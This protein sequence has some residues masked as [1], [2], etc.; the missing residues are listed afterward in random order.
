MSQPRMSDRRRFRPGREALEGRA[1]MSASTARDQALVLWDK[2]IDGPPQEAYI[3]SLSRQLEHG[4]SPDRLAVRLLTSEPNLR[5]TRTL[6]GFVTDLY[7]DVLG[8]APDAEGQQFWVDMLRSGRASRAQVAQT[9]VS[10]GYAA[11][12]APGYISNVTVSKAGWS[13][14]TQGSSTANAGGFYN[15]GDFSAATV[16]I[17]VTGPGT[18]T[19][20]QSGGW[21]VGNNTGSTWRRFTIGL[22]GT[23]KPAFTSSYDASGKF[24]SPSVTAT[25]V[26]YTNGSVPSGGSTYTNAFQPVT[27]ITT[28]AGGTIV[29][30]ETPG[31]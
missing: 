30:Y 17:T 24:A 4:A 14:G 12:T 9:F 18:Y 2:F 23:A 25:T 28:Q 26:A 7:D 5:E 13:S 6:E 21:F 20:D 15:R 8:R 16:T 11:P 27:R 10:V 29:L 31:T 1:L 19:L 22:G 3:R